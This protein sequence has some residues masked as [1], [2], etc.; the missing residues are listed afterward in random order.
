MLADWRAKGDEGADR[1]GATDPYMG[2]PLV[3]LGPIPRDLHKTSHLFQ[4]FPP[5]PSLAFHIFPASIRTSSSKIPPC[6]LCTLW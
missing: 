2:R 3:P 5:Y 4:N 6:S 1:D